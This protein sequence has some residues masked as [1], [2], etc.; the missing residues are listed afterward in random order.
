MPND[1][2]RRPPRQRGRRR[3]PATRLKPAANYPWTMRL[4]RIARIAV[5]TIASVFTL[6]LIVSFFLVGTLRYGSPGPGPSATQPA[7]TTARPA[8]TQPPRGGT[9]P[10]ATEPPRTNG[11]PA[12]T[13]TTP[14]TTLD[15]VSLGKYEQLVKEE[16]RQGHVVYNP[17]QRM[18][19]GQAKEI[20]VRL[21][22]RLRPGV[23]TS[24]AGGGK[25]AVEQVP[26]ATRMRAEL[27]GDAFQ[28]ESR[29]HPAVQ[30]I[31]REGYRSWVWSVTPKKSGKRYLNVT[32]YALLPEEGSEEPL[33]YRVFYRT[34]AVEVSPVQSALGWFGRNWDKVLGVLGVTGVGVFGAIKA[35]PQWI[36]RR[37]QRKTTAALVEAAQGASGDQPKPSG[38]GQRQKDESR[39]PAANA[40][41]DRGDQAATKRHK[42][43]A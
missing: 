41:P 27:T 24:L 40:R 34:I 39:T 22:R 35:I 5:L 18:H 36:R 8:S 2:G 1:L 42:R 26:I 31:G 32:I 9:Q 17:P 4:A 7:D 21:T 25:A 3:S 13:A 43:Q 20:E 30:R 37:K 23:T 29:G 11:G 10:P 6:I 15:P 12:V 19:L 38:P 33:D 14:P 28:I 16:L